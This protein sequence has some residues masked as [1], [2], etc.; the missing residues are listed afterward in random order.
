MRRHRKCDAT[1]YKRRR[2]REKESH[3]LRVAF[4]R[5]EEA[6]RYQIVR[7][8]RVRYEKEQRELLSTRKMLVQVLAN[9]LFV[10]SPEHASKA[11]VMELF[12]IVDV[13]A[14]HADPVTLDMFGSV[15]SDARY[16]AR[17]L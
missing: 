12:R 5:R 7:E 4:R 16:L 17:E 2:Q 6:E 3:K 10:L 1:K 9:R 11:R 15:F 14:D 8:Q 13:V